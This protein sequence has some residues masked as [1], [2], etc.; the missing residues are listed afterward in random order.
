M[1]NV[2]GKKNV[3]N[4]LELEIRRWMSLNYKENVCF[5]WEGYLRVIFVI[6]YLVYLWYVFC[7]FWE[8]VY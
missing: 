3:K 1:L 6:A 4:V 2:L 5:I 7:R 8:S